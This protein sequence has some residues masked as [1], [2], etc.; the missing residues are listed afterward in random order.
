[1]KN[2]TLKILIPTL[3]GV[4]L[5]MGQA[6]AQAAP[7]I[8]EPDPRFDIL[9]AEGNEDVCEFSIKQSPLS[10]A[11][12]MTQAT[13]KAKDCGYHVR[14]EKHDDSVATCDSSGPGCLPGCGSGSEC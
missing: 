5:A 10:L 11:I 12:N 2:I 6:H 13:Q 9:F 4:I 3:F 8:A 14:V 7:P 1:M